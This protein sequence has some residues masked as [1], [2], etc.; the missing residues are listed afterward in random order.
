[1]TRQPTERSGGTV[2]VRGTHDGRRVDVYHAACDRCDARGPAS[3][4]SQR[5]ARRLAAAL[6]WLSE[7]VRVMRSMMQTHV[8]R[9]ECPACRKTT[10]AN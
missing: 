7:R 4:N 3:P 8:W 9:V 5:G 2:R 1:M 6:G 10:D